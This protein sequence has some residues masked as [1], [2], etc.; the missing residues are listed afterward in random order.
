MLS[1]LESVVYAQINFKTPS[2][3]MQTDATESKGW[4]H[5]LIIPFQIDFT[6]CYHFT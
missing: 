6:K 2:K 5:C 3:H 1:G 4:F